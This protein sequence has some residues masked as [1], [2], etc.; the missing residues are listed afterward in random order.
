MSG[1]FSDATCMELRQ[2]LGT[3]VA[4]HLIEAID[5]LAGASGVSPLS[6]LAAD[7][8]FLKSAEAKHDATVEALIQSNVK[9]QKEVSRLRAIVTPAPEEPV[10]ETPV[11]EPPVETAPP[12]VTDVAPPA[13][14]TPPAP[15]EQ[16]PV[17]QPPA[18]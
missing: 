17:E 10:I 11:M 14:T 15:V 5:A 1:V 4:N 13:D 2:R 16:P 18:A 3:N 7:V 12:V 8:A 9:L 6:G